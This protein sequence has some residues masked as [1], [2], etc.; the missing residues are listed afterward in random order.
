MNF[1]IFQD[2]PTSALLFIALNAEHAMCGKGLLPREGRGMD[3]IPTTM[4]P[5]AK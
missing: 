2:K 1:W 4:R 5:S 3:R